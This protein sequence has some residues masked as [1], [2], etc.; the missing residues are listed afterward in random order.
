[1]GTLSDIPRGRRQRRRGLSGQALVAYT[2]QLCHRHRGARDGYP[3]KEGWRDAALERSARAALF[4]EVGAWRR[5]LRQPRLVAGRPASRSGHEGGLSAR[6]RAF[7]VGSTSATQRILRR[8]AMGR[9][10]GG[11]P[12]CRRSNGT[13]SDQASGGHK[14]QRLGAGLHALDGPLG[15]RAPECCPDLVLGPGD[16]Y[17]L[18]ALAGHLGRMGHRE[19]WRWCVKVAAW[20]DSWWRHAM[21]HALFRRGPREDVVQRTPQLGEAPMGRGHRKARK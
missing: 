4:T 21:R 16:C 15:R 8:E 7:P 14:E 18:A 11:L 10:S 17:R 20:K 9:R 19:P 2:P 3:P 13:R 12:K 6:R 5:L 1:M